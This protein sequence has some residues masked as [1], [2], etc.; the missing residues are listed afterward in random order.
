MVEDCHLRVYFLPLPHKSSVPFILQ[1]LKSLVFLT[2]PFPHRSQ[3][4]NLLIATL[5]SRNTN[6]S[7]TLVLVSVMSVTCMAL[8]K[9]GMI[10]MALRYN[11]LQGIA[12]LSG[13]H[14]YFSRK[15]FMDF[16]FYIFYFCFLCIRNLKTLNE[17]GVHSC[18]LE[19]LHRHRRKVVITLSG[20]RCHNL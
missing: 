13:I 4:F 7:L 5:L 12:Q 1:I 17:K 19:V 20:E 3:L 11:V 16:I 2:H 18:R 9:G 15:H 10:L 6:C 8:L 14:I